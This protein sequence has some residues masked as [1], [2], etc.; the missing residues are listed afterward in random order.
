M[1]DNF[2]RRVLLIKFR[3]RGYSQYFQSFFAFK[4]FHFFVFL[5]EIVKWRSRFEPN[6]LVSLNYLR[7]FLGS[8][9]IWFCLLSVWRSVWGASLNIKKIPLLRTFVFISKNISKLYYN[10]SL[11]Y[12]QSLPK[13]VW[14]LNTSQLVW[15]RM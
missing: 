12:E 14:K 1:G 6:W 11:K 3:N 4:S 15:A 7:F 10:I 5:I 2:L 8:C 9:I 13:T